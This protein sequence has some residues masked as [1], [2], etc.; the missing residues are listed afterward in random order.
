MASWSSWLLRW[1][2]TENTESRSISSPQR[3]TRTGWSAVDGYTSTIDPR[4]AISPRPSTW[5][6]RRYPA[7]R[8]ARA[9]RRDRSGRPCAGRSARCPRRA[10]RAVARARA[11]APR[12][13]RRAVAALTQPPHDPQAAAHGLERRRHAF[14][15]QRLPR[16]EELDRV[17]R[18]SG[19]DRPA[20]RSASAAVGTASRI[21][22]AGEPVDPGGEQ[23]AGR[24]GDRDDLAA[25]GRDRDDARV[26]GQQPRQLGERSR[27]HRRTMTRPT[28][29]LIL[30]RLRTAGR[31]GPGRSGRRN[32]VSCRLL[33]GWRRPRS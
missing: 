32:E 31:R 13:R 22:R 4:T 23:R 25:P 10:G 2:A 20:M 21:G 27:R 7:R 14:E 33:R 29:P 18:A 30:A 3:S 26:L 24:L 16:R 5:Y 17:G 11:P 12:R 28:P 19:R 1:S 15:R 6:S 9:G 8:A